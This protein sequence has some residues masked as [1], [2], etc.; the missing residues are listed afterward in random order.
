MAWQIIKTSLNFIFNN[1]A[2]ALRVSILP[3][4]AYFAILI[5]ID[6]SDFAQQ[7]RF[8]SLAGVLAALF[9]GAWIAVGW[10]RYIL[11]GDT[12]NSWIP[13]LHWQ[14]LRSYILKLF[15][16]VVV[17]VVSALPFILVAFVTMQSV[18][19]ITNF[20]LVFIPFVAGLFFFRFGL[21]LPAAALDQPLSFGIS[22]RATGEISGAVLITIVFVTLFNGVLTSI[23]TA[24][25]YGPVSILWAYAAG[26]M[27]A[28]LGVSVLT[29]L[30]G[31]LIEKRDLY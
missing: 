12:P 27:Q 11:N 19:V 14:N 30:Y 22:W 28:M 25:P 31:Y 5:V 24:M 26:W 16:L 21:V 18:P 3:Y 2:I 15:F 17:L 4:T 6:T 20:S 10:H 7:S 9:F 8:F 1:F 13:G 23:G 29:T